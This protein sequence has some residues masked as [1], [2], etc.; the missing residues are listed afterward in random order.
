MTKNDRLTILSATKQFAFY[1]LPDFDDKQR[2]KYFNSLENEMKII[3]R[4]SNP[5]LN[6][7]CALQVGYFKA[8][9]IFFN[10]EI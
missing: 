6:I 9:K 8:K 7:Y 1:G 2:R 4:N 5:H 3:M 10:G